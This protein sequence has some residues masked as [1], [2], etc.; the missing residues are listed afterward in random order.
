MPS[1]TNVVA[2][3]S[4]PR[5]GFLPIKNFEVNNFYD[6]MEIDTSTPSYSSYASLQGMVVDYMTRMLCGVE[7]KEA[8]KVSLLGAKKVNEEK[9]ASRLLNSIKGLDNDSIFRAFKLVGYD[10]AVRRGSK[11]FTSVDFISPDDTILRN[12]TIMVKRGVEFINNQG[13]LLSTGFT[14]D[15]G[16][17]S[18]VDS[19]DGD[20]LTDGGL[21]DFKTSI[22]KPDSKDTLQILIYYILGFHSRNDNFKKVKTIGL[23][24]PLRNESYKINVSSISDDTLRKVSHDVIGYN[25]YALPYRWYETRGEDQNVIGNFLKQQINDYFGNGFDPSEFVDGIYEISKED[26]WTFI[27]DRLK[28]PKPKLTWTAKIKMIK[29]NGYYMFF[30]ISK[31]GRTSILRGGKLKHT[32]RS[33]DYYYDNIALYGDKVLQVFSKYWDE[34]YDIR[35]ALSQVEPDR[36]IIKQ[37]L[38]MGE[39]EY[40]NYNH[41]DYRGRVHG[42]IVD[43]DYFN[44]IYLNPF[45]GSITPYYARSMYQKHVYQNVESLLSVQRPDLLP[46][47]R[48]KVAVGNNTLLNN[49]NNTNALKLTSSEIDTFSEIVYDTDM[50]SVSNKLRPLQNIYDFGLVTVWYDSVLP[51]RKQIA[52]PENYS[53]EMEEFFEKKF[54]LMFSKLKDEKNKSSKEHR[55]LIWQTNKKIT[56]PLLL[57]GIKKIFSQI[58]EES[59]NNK[60]IVPLTCEWMPL[61]GYSH[62]NVIIN[63]KLC[64]AFDC[65]TRVLREKE[66]YTEIVLV[67]YEDY[68]KT[69]KNRVRSINVVF[70]G[71]KNDTVLALHGNYKMENKDLIRIESYDIINMT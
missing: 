42:C 2:Q 51:Q 17:T 43:I 59:D 29:R 19:G 28:T 27:K 20:Y 9:K 5:L 48:R 15:G 57:F 58:E 45:D 53:P 65:F 60:E 16:Y 68:S 61:K 47:Y 24:N 26:Y 22:K 10:V 66:E 37:A 1:V 12:I 69:K 7:K 35:D 52:A 8:F 70:C 14:F 55:F 63:C 32:E 67:R 49:S 54:R 64:E 40:I 13:D 33:I 25:V 41:F 30:S 23:F 36:K 62:T 6:G 21:W 11:Y 44:H 56:K 71:G 31:K 38:K 34:L 39:Y 4:Q 46:D 18:I 50:Y 3:F